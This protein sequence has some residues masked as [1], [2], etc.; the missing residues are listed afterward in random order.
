MRLGL[1]CISCVMQV[2]YI[3]K[4]VFSLPGPQ[5][6]LT[7]VCFALTWVVFLFSFKGWRMVLHVIVSLRNTNCVTMAAPSLRQRE[8]CQP[9][10]TPYTVCLVAGKKQHFCLPLQVAAKSPWKHLLF[11]SINS[12]DHFLPSF[13]SFTRDFVDAVWFPGALSWMDGLHSK[14]VPRN[15]FSVFSLWWAEHQRSFLPLKLCCNYPS[16]GQEFLAQHLISMDR[17]LLHR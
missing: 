3:Q 1:A 11:H 12:L 13:W 16:C 10:Q 5:T 8:R 6:P 4:P 17:I 15:I 2:N 7:S 14:A 9:L